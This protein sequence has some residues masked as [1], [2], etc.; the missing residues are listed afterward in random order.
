M[1]R[2]GSVAAL[3]HDA[4][5]GSTLWP[6]V[7]CRPG[8]DPFESLAVALSRSANVGQGV[9]TLAEM[10]AEFQK[11]EK[12][13]HLIAR[14]SLPENTPDMRLVVVVDQFEEVFTLCRKEELREA[15]TRNLLYAAKVAQGQTLVILTMRADFYGKCAANAELATAFSDHHVLVEP[16]TDDDLRR[17]I[18]RPIQLAGCELEAGLVELLLQDVRY[19]ESDP[20][21]CKRPPRGGRLDDRCQGYVLTDPVG[22]ER[23]GSHRW[24]RKPWHR[25]YKRGYASRCRFH[26]GQSERL[27]SACR[28]DLSQSGGALRSWFPAACLHPQATCRPCT[29]RLP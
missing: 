23:C 19:R 21:C 16:M 13:L 15:V 8:P 5:Q 26:D 12:T 25:A 28:T 29:G 22:S 11:N 4:I 6:V 17:A 24:H 2:A 3:K 9:A 20:I 14:Q 27:E 18:E 7:I 1:A 10:I